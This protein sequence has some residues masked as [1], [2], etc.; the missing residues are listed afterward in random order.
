MAD[1][2]LERPVRSLLLEMFERLSPEG[3]G[4]G[5]RVRVSA[6][7]GHGPQVRHRPTRSVRSRSVRAAIAERP[8]PCR[9]RRRSSIDFLFTARSSRWSRL[10]DRLRTSGCGR[11]RRM[12][13]LAQVRGALS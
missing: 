2:M 8:D 9:S 11:L 10:R 3:R 4:V 1:A 13:A 7:R 5:M 6:N 12:A